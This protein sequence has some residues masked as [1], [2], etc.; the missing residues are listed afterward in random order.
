MRKISNILVCLLKCL[1]LLILLVSAVC[2]TSSNWYIHTYGNTGFDSIVYTLTAKLDGVE[3]GLIFDFLEQG[4]FNGLI[5]WGVFGFLLFWPFR[6]HLQM[7]LFG[8]VKLKLYP[9]P[10][11]LSGLAA[12]LLSGAFLKDAAENM[13]L[14]EYVESIRN[15]STFYEDY[16]INP[17]D[18]EISFPEQKRNLIYIYLESMETTY[19]SEN[20]GGGLEENI[21]P[22]LYRLA[23]ENLNFSHNAAVGGFESAPG[24]TWTIGAMVG[25]TSGV[26]LKILPG[27][28]ENQLGNDGSILP[29]VTAL[30]DILRENGYYQALM[31]GSDAEFGGREQYFE[32]HGIDRI[33]DYDTAQED[34]IIPEGYFVWWGMEDEYLFEYAKQELPKIADREEPFAFTMLT[35]DTHRTDGYVCDRC[36]DK[37]DE[38]YEN[39]NVCSSRQVYE[40]VQWLQQQ[41]FYENTTVVIAGDHLTMDG[42]YISRQVDMDYERH[43]YNC[44]M[45][46]P[47]QA[48]NSKNRRFCALDMFPTTLGAL[49]CSIDGDRL[50]LGTNLFSDRATL[51]EELG[52][53]EFNRGEAAFSQ[54]Y[55]DQ[56]E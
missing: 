50:A 45:N 5:L 8:R 18:V 25:H 44:F 10:L 9:L 30:P 32:G 6:M 16:Y 40:F 35:V 13:K 20:E 42:A 48:R 19:F 54:F 4:L 37:Y 52:V 51:M 14:S 7:T 49:G 41:D 1:L 15:P 36:E 3:K 12:A 47:A 38:Q 27:Q 22:E 31:L 2:F 34:G 17:N 29:G 56:F 28:E 55:F 46:V 23:E 39:V 11:I 33:Y 43:V 53:E 24:T 21:I 26:P